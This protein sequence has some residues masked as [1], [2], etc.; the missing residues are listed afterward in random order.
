MQDFDQAIRLNPNHFR[1]FYNRGL[2]WEAKN[3]PSALADFKKFS[4]L[5]PSD[6]TG[7]QAVERMTRALKGK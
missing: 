3:F 4:E 5:A 2:L 6:P 1:A 7:P